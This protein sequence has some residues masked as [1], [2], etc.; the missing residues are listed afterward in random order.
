MKNRG[1]ENSG[2]HL[3]Q[4]EEIKHRGETEEIILDNVKYFGRKANQRGGNTF[5]QQ[6][7]GRKG[8][9][10]RRFLPGKRRKNLPTVMNEG[11]MSKV[12]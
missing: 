10:E 2:K 4:E 9:K 8:R 3:V 6:K 1:G 7:E 12:R 11:R 5:V